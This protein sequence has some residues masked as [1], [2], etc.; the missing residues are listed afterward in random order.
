MTSLAVALDRKHK[1]HKR[2]LDQWNQGVKNEKQLDAWREKNAQSDDFSEWFPALEEER[3]RLGIPDIREPGRLTC[4]RGVWRMNVIPIRNPDTDEVLVNKLHQ[5]GSCSTVFGTTNHLETCCSDTCQKAFTADKKAH[6]RELRLERDK[7]LT[8]ALAARK[9]ICLAC[10]DEFALKR[11][12]GK[13]CSDKCRKQLTRTSSEARCE[14]VPAPQQLMAEKDYG[15][16][17]DRLSELKAAFIKAMFSG[18]GVDVINQQ[19]KPL[20]EQIK[21]ERAKRMLNL[22]YQEAPALTLWIQR[23]PESFQREA[24]D[25]DGSPTQ[26][27]ILGPALVKKLRRHNKSV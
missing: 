14:L 2:L 19:V 10:G 22:L 26:R 6:A 13:T 3:K 21:A 24:F 12:S 7:A 9:G 15:K 11:S 17:C 5:C 20:Q 23:Q 18:G 25:P 1:P 27:E 4:S 16:L 8:E